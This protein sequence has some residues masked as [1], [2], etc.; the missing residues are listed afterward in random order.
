MHEVVDAVVA[1]LGHCDPL[2]GEVAQQRADGS[3]AGRVHHRTSALEG[4]EHRFE[5]PHR[6]VVVAAIDVL[7]GALERGRR[8]DRRGNV[9][10][11]A[12]AGVAMERIGEWRIGHP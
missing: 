10:Q 2:R 11:F 8:P 3:H 4:A 5:P 12:C 9:G 1:L 6:L 7:P